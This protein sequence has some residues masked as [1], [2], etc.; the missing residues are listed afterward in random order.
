MIWY[1]MIH[2]IWY[3][4]IFNGIWIDTSW[5]Y[6][7]HLDTNNTHNT[8]NGTY[9]MT[10]HYITIQAASQRCSSWP[11]HNLRDETGPVWLSWR[12]SPASCCSSYSGKHSL[13]FWRDQQSSAVS[14]SQLP[15]TAWKSVL[16]PLTFF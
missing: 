8:E 12:R 11:V 15:N 4:H 5:Q 13:W 16:R 1:D 3:I 7:T 10:I 2:M 9:I 14:V 6:S